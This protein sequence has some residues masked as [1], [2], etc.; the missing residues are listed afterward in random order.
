MAGNPYERFQRGDLIL[1]DEL[2]VDRTVLAN[3]RTLL[4]YIRTGL[5]FG[6]TGAGAIEFFG[7]LI[8]L[9]LGWGMVGLAFLVVALGVWRFR[10]VAGRISACRKPDSGPRPSQI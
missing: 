5:A 3:E 9:L 6:V 2:A 4:S 10:Q 1:R 8:F 7:S